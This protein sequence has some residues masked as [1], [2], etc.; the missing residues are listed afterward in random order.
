MAVNTAVR[1]CLTQMFEGDRFL[2][3][4][5]GD[6]PGNAEDLVVGPC[7]KRQS[8]VGFGEKTLAG[9]V[10]RTV[11]VEEPGRYLRIVRNG[12]SGIAGKLYLMRTCNAGAHLGRRALILMAGQV[13]VSYLVDGNTQ[14]HSV[15]KR[16]GQLLTVAL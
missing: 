5:I 7:G 2:T 12:A 3:V 11:F 10:D 16:L 1:Q 15:E 6:R 8:L 14:I 9:P 13:A 4:N